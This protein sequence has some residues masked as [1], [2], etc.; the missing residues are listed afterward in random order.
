MSKE[1]MMT[2][3]K[4]ERREDNLVKLTAALLGSGRSTF[5]TDIGLGLGAS[6]CAHFA[7][8]ALHDIERHT[9]DW[10]KWPYD[11]AGKPL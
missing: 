3:D 5:D 8:A 2:R 10:N 6:R 1:D 4:T 11:Q 9:A 7:A